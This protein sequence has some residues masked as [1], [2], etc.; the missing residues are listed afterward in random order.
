MNAIGVSLP[1]DYISENYVTREACVVRETIGPPSGGL[2]FLKGLGV[3]S[4]ELRH[5]HPKLSHSDM[6]R[7]LGILGESD[8][9]ITIHSESPPDS[10]EWS[11][12]DLFPW[13]KILEENNIVN[14]DI[15]TVAL[16]PLQDA[17]SGSVETLRKGTVSMI[18]KLT[19]LQNNWK[20]RYH[21]ALENQR[22]K[23]LVDPG[24]TFDEIF[25][26]FSE[27]NRSEV[28]ICW[29]FGHGYANHIK[30]GHPL[31]PP[32]G[33]V[34]AATHTHIHDLGPTGAT[35]WPFSE[36]AVPLSNYVNLLLSQGYEGTLNLELGFD[37]FEGVENKIELLEL[38][39]DK[40]IR[41][42]N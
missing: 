27:L 3:T 5:L 24:T 12:L 2:S 10:D 37:R 20:Q 8:I 23:G 39:I 36:M 38:S 25:A 32:E 22:V 28:G 18:R 33:F 30:N 42:R 17:G 15:I 1:W 14:Q 16:H 9:G 7:T 13:F 26:M 21:F 34:A 6:T 4:I 41:L 29:D 19:E 35:H 11:V 40:L 31:L